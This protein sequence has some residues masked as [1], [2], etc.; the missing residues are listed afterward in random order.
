MKPDLARGRS[1]LRRSRGSRGGSETWGKTRWSWLREGGVKAR[2]AREAGNKGVTITDVVHEG[3]Q[4]FVRYSDVGGKTIASEV[5]VRERRPQS[6]QP[7]KQRTN[8]GLEGLL[9]RVS[10]RPE[11]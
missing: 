6:A 3:D 4:V 9:E 11:W 1:S 5:D 10:R 7:V 2:A 8:L